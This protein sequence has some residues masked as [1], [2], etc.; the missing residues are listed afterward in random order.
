MTLFSKVRRYSSNIRPQNGTKHGSTDNGGRGWATFNILLVHVKEP[1]QQNNRLTNFLVRL[2][3]ERL[4]STAVT[5]VFL[6]GIRS[7]VLQDVSDGN[8]KPRAS[9]ARQRYLAWIHCMSYPPANPW[10]HDVLT[11]FRYP[12]IAGDLL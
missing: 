11:V 2:Q 12:D 4:C 9:P 5:S 6:R 7:S 3:T 10:N 8:P 1:Q